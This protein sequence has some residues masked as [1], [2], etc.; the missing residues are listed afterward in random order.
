MEK[1]S[2][3]LTCKEYLTI[4]ALFHAT[5]DNDSRQALCY[6]WYDVSKDLF[7]ATDG[8]I[9]RQEQIGWIDSKKPEESF[10]IDKNDMMLTKTQLR[11]KYGPGFEN[12]GIELTYESKRYYSKDQTEIVYPAIWKVVPDPSKSIPLER[13]CIEPDR[14][15]QFMKSFYVRP[16]ALIMQWTGELGAILIFSMDKF[17]AKTFVGIWM[18]LRILKN[19]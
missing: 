11:S 5:A 3:S 16:T 7:V 18:P 4:Q 6:V 15:T 10:L 9:M 1:K 14:I 8:H 12:C 2:I 17:G 13:I 19:N